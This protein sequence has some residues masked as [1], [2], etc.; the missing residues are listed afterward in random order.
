MHCFSKWTVENGLDGETCIN[1]NHNTSDV[2]MC[3][4]VKI[5]DCVDRTVFCTAPPVPDLARI[6]YDSSMFNISSFVEFGSKIEYS[7][8]G[9]VQEYC[10]VDM[11]DFLRK[12]FPNAIFMIKQIVYFLL[13][14][15]C[16]YFCP[17]LVQ[18]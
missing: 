8:P 6:S 2:L 16:Q 4:G 12:M 5:P 3:S 9:L 14:S 17:G 11:V 10:G 15:V 7:C 1:W 18:N 13:L